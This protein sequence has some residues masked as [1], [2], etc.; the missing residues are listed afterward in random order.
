[1]LARIERF[2]IAV[3]NGIGWR[4]RAAD[5]RKIHQLWA[6]PPHSL[7]RWRRWLLQRPRCA[8]RGR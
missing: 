3:I 8:K 5:P 4:N 2:V 1:M 7:P 6:N